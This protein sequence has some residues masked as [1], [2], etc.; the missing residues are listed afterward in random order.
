MGIGFNG[1]RHLY[2]SIVEV[3]RLTDMIVDGYSVNSWHRVESMLD[4]CLGSVG[5]IQCRLAI[6]FARPGKDVLVAPVAGRVPDRI[7]VMFCDLTPD[8]RAGD[9][10]KAIQG[11]VAGHI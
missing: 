2:S 10:I 1:P 7:G 4:P 9:R 3:Y 11:P 8:L 5:M 6:G